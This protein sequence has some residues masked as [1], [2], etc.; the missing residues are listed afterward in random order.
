MLGNESGDVTLVWTDG[1]K[2][3]AR[4]VPP[5]SYALR[6]TR[7]ERTQGGVTWFISSTGPAG[8]AM[9]LRAGATRRIAVTDTVHFEAMVQRAGASGALQLGFAVRAADGRGLSV[10][11]DDRRVPVT[12][13]VLSKAGKVLASGT[14]NYG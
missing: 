13:E 12:F 4:P 2:D 5:G 6:T 7:V 3:Q 11:R 1:E 8:D 9:A 10:Y 14:M